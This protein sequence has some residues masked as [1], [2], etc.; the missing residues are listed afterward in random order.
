M[1]NFMSNLSDF[2]GGGGGGAS[3]VRRQLFTANGTWTKPADII[4]EQVWVTI[5]GGGSSGN[6]DAADRAGS[7]GAYIA[8]L[9]VDVSGTSSETVTIGAGGASVTGAVGSA[10]AVSSFG[11]LVSVDGGIAPGI[12]D[13]YLSSLTGQNPGTGY[14]GKREI[15]AIPSVFGAPVNFS[16]NGNIGGSGLLLDTSGTKAAD[17]TTGGGGNG[18]GGMGYGAGGAAARNTA[19]ASTAGV[20]GAILVEWLESV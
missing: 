20:D 9:S 7:S 2:T 5:I 15:N 17:Q 14:F 18:V 3:I 1:E 13:D 10:G 4:G 8:R 19:I 16:G 6:S 12:S 11:S